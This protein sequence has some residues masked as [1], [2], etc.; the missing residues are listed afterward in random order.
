[1]IREASE[2]R[3]ILDS[4]HANQVPPCSRCPENK[5]FTVE[6]RAATII[7]DR[8]DAVQPRHR[9]DRVPMAPWTTDPWSS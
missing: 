6:E 7:R 5:A 3:V 8:R 1:M 9:L 2:R 4:V